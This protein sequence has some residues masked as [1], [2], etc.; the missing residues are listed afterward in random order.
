MIERHLPGRD[1]GDPPDAHVET[2]A[3]PGRVADPPGEPGDH[4]SR[5]ADPEATVPDGDGDLAGA[6]AERGSIPAGPASPDQ[7]GTIPARAELTTEVAEPVQQIGPA[8]TRSRLPEVPGFALHGEL[9]RGGMGVVYL[10]RRALLNRPCA[11]KMILAGDYASPEQTVRFLGEAEAAARIRHPNVLQ[12]YSIGEHD[13][14]TYVELEFADG[15]SLADRLDGTPWPGR[16]AA[17][18]VEALARAVTE[19]HRI[20]IVH[21][22]LKPGNVLFMA[23]GTAKVSDFGLARS[24]AAN[25]GL[26]A[27][28][29]I[30][31]S[32]SY[33]A[34]EQAAG[35]TREAGPPADVY[36]LGAILYELLTGRPPFRGASILE[37]LEQVK[38]VEPVPPGRLVPGTPCDLETI[39]L[40][41]LQKD[42]G[43]RY[44]SAAELADDLG[45]FLRDEPITARPV[46]RPERLARW[47]RR[48][49]LVASLIGAVA[50]VLLTGIVTA[51]HFAVQAAKRERDATEEA[52]RADRAAEAAAIS[53][54]REGQARILSDHRYY[55][56]ETSRAQSDGLQGKVDLVRQKLHALEPQRPGDLDMLGFEWHYLDRTCQNDLRT[57]AGHVGGVNGVACSPDG[58]RVVSAGD[59]G[60]IRLWDL[61]TGRE[62]RRFEGH[63]GAV[64]CVTCGPDGRLLASWGE[65]RTL[66]AWA[67]DTGQQ[68]WSLPTTRL[69]RASGLAFSPDGRQLAA[70][71][72]IRSVA[73]L[74]AATGKEQLTLRTDPQEA[75]ACVAFSPDGRRLAS[76]S[77]RA[78]LMWDAQD[79]KRVLT[80]HTPQ[81]LYTA[82]FSPDGRY[83]ATAGLGP[84]VRIWDTDGG[85]ELMTLAGHDATVPGLAFS[86]DGRR[87]ATASEDRTVKI[88]DLQTGMAVTGLVGHGDAVS[89][90]AFDRDGWRLMSGS[91]DGTIKIW[92]AVS[93]QKC[94]ALSGHGDTVFSIAF[95]PDGTRL[96]S[97]GNDMTVRIWDVRDGLELLCLYGHCASVYQVAFSPDGRLLASASAAHR[98]D[99]GVF[100]GE[101]R[102]WDAR[103]GRELRTISDHPGAVT[104]LAFSRDG[105]L[106]SAEDDGTA[107]L[108]D[109]STG[110]R[111]ATIRAHATALRDVAFSPD[112]R[113][114]ATCSDAPP[115]GP[116][117]VNLRDAMT[118]REVMSWGVSRTF[119]HHLA[120]SHDS[121]LLAGA[122]DDRA[123]HLWDVAGREAERVLRG[124]GRPVYRVAFSLDDRRI[125]SGSLDHTLKIWD[126]LSGMEML[127]FPAH[128]VA[129]LGV[130]FS[131]DGRQLASS[132]YDRLI[133]VWDGTPPTGR[134]TA[135]REAWSLIT[136]LFA[137]GLS[138]AEVS[139]RIG[140]D[141]SIGDEV[142]RIAL[143]F[144]EPRGASLRRQAAF[145]HVWGAINRGRPKREILD[146]IR[147]DNKIDDA[148]RRE[149]LRFVERYPENIPYLHWCSRLAVARRGLAPVQYREALRQAE[150]VCR[151]DPSD[152]TYW[153]TFG[154]AEY[155][156]GRFTEALSALTCAARLGRS[157]IEPVNL[158][159]RA[160]ALFRLGRA[161]ESRDRLRELHERLKRPDRAQDAE[162][163]G[164]LREAED[165]IGTT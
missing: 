77:D 83:L 124:H 121:R 161:K 159:F 162:T 44:A 21:R 90:V 93:D 148:F 138:D 160:M 140:R 120:F 155:R 75:R 103:S 154:M 136:S 118:G 89:A 134:G 144:V 76:I 54:E 74:E 67:L 82:V 95:S 1:R 128:G 40:K 73:I 100:P 27:T 55:A 3:D 122:G 70:P 145:D 92:E 112:G 149:A 2:E 42:P 23:D 39:V 106:A 14:R 59:D 105:R 36:S 19:A 57:L 32:P 107:R 46:G 52:R 139:A 132:G 113:W 63:R 35:R 4:E 130:A 88:W 45:R 94:R 97:G 22:D 16:R 109:P 71:T 147:D 18:M 115:G 72:D 60:T 10:A 143:A 31:G 30:L 151:A 87:L 131:P 80:I 56:A 5:I 53:R 13:G 84:T 61:A 129:V 12:V 110:E 142:R 64:W 146:E 8:A 153:T 158:A 62:L 49:P 157:P 114:L 38:T 111:L 26:T 150:A 101:V 108:W 7:E 79:G 102:I 126:V 69:N 141:A 81:P 33:M 37:T 29:S 58:R 51:S 91:V 98:R 50:A 41:C 85:R 47:C 116:G 127:S 133:K 104:G 48:N 117:E 24:V 9:G 43:R 34:P 20:G 25:S 156:Q 17:T 6:R 152:A 123:I 68:R 164:W 137:L 165:L 11:L 78:V 86:P 28:D 125:A 15:G 119:I 96:A 99:G 135:R 66:R 65:D 163:D